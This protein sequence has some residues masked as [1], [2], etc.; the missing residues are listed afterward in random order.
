MKEPLMARK[1]AAKIQSMKSQQEK[2]EKISKEDLLSLSMMYFRKY[3]GFKRKDLAR[4]LR[5]G[6]RAI[7]RW[8]EG[9]DFPPPAIM[10]LYVKKMA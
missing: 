6:E 2:G 10:E 4:Y 5:V 3:K 9:R 1:L 7:I 8:E